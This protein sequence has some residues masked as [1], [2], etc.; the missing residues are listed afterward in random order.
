MA[1]RLYLRSILRDLIRSESRVT[2]CQA[3]NAK[4]LELLSRHGINCSEKLLRNVLVD[5]QKQGRIQHKTTRARIKNG[6]YERARTIYCVASCDT[7]SGALLLANWCRLRGKTVELDEDRICGQL[8][9]TPS[10]LESWVEAAVGKGWLRLEVK[11]CAGGDVRRL[12]RTS[13]GIPYVN[14]APKFVKNSYDEKKKVTKCESTWK[15]WTPPV[16]QSPKGALLAA[17]NGGK[18]LPQADLAARLDRSPKTVQ[19]LLKAM[20]AAGE[21]H[22]VKGPT[23]HYLVSL[24]P[25]AVSSTPAKLRKARKKSFATEF[26]ETTASAGM[27]TPATRPERHAHYASLYDAKHVLANTLPELETRG[28]VNHLHRFKATV[29]QFIR[30]AASVLDFGEYGRVYGYQPL[31]EDFWDRVAGKLVDGF[32]E[33]MQRLHSNQVARCEARKAEVRP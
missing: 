33:R 17:L 15:P 21:I 7:Q 14:A 3:T 18:V 25:I 26:G 10:Q 29:P 11:R 30:A 19:R 13:K 5:L 28:F 12:E 22:R 23:G 20:L 32:A 31:P 27:H 6:R 8:G 24:E 4:L 16:S 2:A 1:T 9:C